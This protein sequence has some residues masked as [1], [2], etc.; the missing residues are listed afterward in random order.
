MRHRISFIFPALIL[1]LVLGAFLLLPQGGAGA[2][3][4]DATDDTG[5][6][7]PEDVVDVGPPAHTTSEEAES[8]DAQ[9]P[10]SP[11]SAVDATSHATSFAYQGHLTDGGQPADGSYD[12][13]FLLYDAEVGGS[14]IGGTITAE[15]VAVSEG[16]FVVGLDFGGSVFAGDARYLEIGVRAGDSTDTFTVLAPRRPVTPTPYAT[17][18]YDAD[19]LD[20]RDASSFASAI[21]DHD[22]RY[23][24]KRRGTQ[25]SGSLDAGQTRSYFTFG[26]PTDEIV[27]WSMHPTT[28]DGRVDWSVDIRLGDNDRFTYYLTV[29]NRGSSTTSFDARYIIFR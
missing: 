5:E 26:W 23:Y 17:F 14:Q 25:F 11:Q 28:V 16:L 27:Y 18:A 13:R 22:S 24:R 7:A 4:P 15:D 1:A 21:H 29:T 9:G 20:G 19:R 3:G 10:T 2:Q 8:S 6:L 12:L